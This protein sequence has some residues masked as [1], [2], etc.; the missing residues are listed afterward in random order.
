VVHPS[1]TV[2]AGQDVGA[3]LDA[4]AD[5]LRT[6]A[7]R[8]RQEGLTLAVESPLPHLIGGHPEEFQSIL[9]RLDDDVRVCLDT[10]HTF[11]GRFWD[12]FIEVA[13]GRLTH[14]H[15]N[16]NRGTFDDHL[17]PGD[18]RIDWPHVVDTLRQAS[19]A[20]WVMLELHCPAGDLGPFFEGA[21]GRARLL[22]G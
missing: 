8:C 3:R 18:G 4:A 1:D 10:G 5:G 19:F 7:E 20:G 15:A 12:R 2:R 21:M 14:V 6:V 13:A 17:I 9:R 16:D 11:L 22:E